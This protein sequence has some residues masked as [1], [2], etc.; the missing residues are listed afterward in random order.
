MALAVKWPGPTAGTLEPR[1][2][3]LGGPWKLTHRN[4]GRCS[5]LASPR[6]AVEH[7]H[8]VFL[9]RDPVNS[10]GLPSPSK[11]AEVVSVMARPVSKF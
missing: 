7:S 6:L 8:V 1:C 10:Y 4:A 9:D 11:I 3:N 5:R 2:N